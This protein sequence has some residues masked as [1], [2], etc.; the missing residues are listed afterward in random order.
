M[1]VLTE[2]ANQP[3]IAEKL[4][5]DEAFAERLTKYGQQYQMQLVQAQNAQTGRIGTAPASVGSVQ[6]QGIQ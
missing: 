3:D 1:Q 4:Q 6:S 5:S 2:Y